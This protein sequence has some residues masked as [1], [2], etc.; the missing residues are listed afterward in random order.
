KKREN[1]LGRLQNEYAAALRR[2]KLLHSD[3]E[4]EASRTSKE[5]AKLTHYSDLKRDVDATRQ[6]KDNMTPKIRESALASAMQVSDIRVIEPATPPS[7]PHSPNPILNGLLGFF[8]GVCVGGLFLTYR[9]RGYRG[10]REPGQISVELNMPE[11]G[12]IPAG[13]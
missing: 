1:I 10:I 11:L 8:T 3:Y 13:N 6:P 12:V 7:S 2:E 9:A 5:S 4:K